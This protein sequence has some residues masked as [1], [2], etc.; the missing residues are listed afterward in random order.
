M[1]KVIVTL[2]AF[3]AALA[4]NGTA[5]A[6][7]SGGVAHCDGCHTMHNSENGVINANGGVVGTGLN[8]YL[9]KGSDNSSTCLNCH[10]NIYKAMSTD[11]SAYTAAGDFFYLTVNYAYPRHT[12]FGYTHGH[13]VIAGDYG[14]VQDGILTT[15]PSDGT[16]RFPAAQLG[17]NSCH[18]P[19]GKIANN[20]NPLP[21]S[22]SGSYGA[23]NPTDGSMLGNFRLLGG[24]GYDGGENVKALGI[25][26]TAPAPIARTPA[27]VFGQW[28]AETNTNHVDDGSGMSE[29]CANCH[30]GFTANTSLQHRHPASN[31]AHLDGFSNNYNMY[32]ATGDMT[33]SQSTSYDRLVPFERGITDR[34]LLD[35]RR[36]D[37][38]N[39]QSNVMCL[40]CHRA[41]AS[42]FANA[43][44]WDFVT[45][46]LADSPQ[47]RSAQAV[48]IYY[49][50][51]ITTRYNP[52]QRSL[53][54]KCHVQD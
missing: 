3:A 18:D 46:L 14:L 7:H 5:L 22:G 19:H 25:R 17:C 24:L 26:F 27:G 28:P 15:G 45:E 34:T 36:T 8:Q 48:H 49:G 30:T 9:T 43:G 20:A 39:S 6:F 2:A 13:N 1:K 10:Q 32:V 54:N 23:P 41:H 16:V 47:L 29:W 31:D 11:G 12:S 4:V 51:D 35:T 50:D 44:R 53:C 21:I 52:W 33:G 40:T 42:P 37:G 38:P